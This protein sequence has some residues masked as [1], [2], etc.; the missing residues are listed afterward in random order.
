LLSIG[1][2][3]SGTGRADVLSEYEIPGKNDSP[4]GI[5][6][7]DGNILLSCNASAED[8]KAGNNKHLRKLL[9]K[10]TSDADADADVDSKEK[11]QRIT[12][13]DAVD[14]THSKDT[15]AYIKV[16]KVSPDGKTLA[17]VTSSTIHFVDVDTLKESDKIELEDKEEVLDVAFHENQFAYILKRKVVLITEKADKKKETLTYDKFSPSYQLAKLEFSHTGSLIIGVNLAQ[18]QGILLLESRVAPNIDPNPGHVSLY[19]EPMTTEYD[20][21]I[22][23]D[24]RL[25]T[26]KARVVTNKPSKI[27]SLAVEGDLIAFATN[28]NSIVISDVQTFKN[29]KTLKKVHSFAITSVKITRDLKHVISVSVS[30]TVA[31]YKIPKNLKVDYWQHLPILYFILLG[32]FLY[33]ANNYVQENYKDELDEIHRFM[34]DDGSTPEEPAVET[35]STKTVVEVVTE[36]VVKEGDIVHE[37]IESKGWIQSEDGQEVDDQILEKG[38]SL[39]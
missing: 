11:G 29:H 37:V 10:N 27:T 2:D 15:T 33:H 36:Y 31:V 38:S 20:P 13:V 26:F 34:F 25:R 24:T 22:K 35:G 4:T 8:I 1:S 14:V 12:A 21:K 6:Y 17:L 19:N 7:T 28:D 9:L 5:V 18:K 39:I 3:S 30:G 16:T 32:I 23:T